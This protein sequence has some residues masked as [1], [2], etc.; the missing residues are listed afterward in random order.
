MDYTQ[1][2]VDKILEASEGATPGPWEA[3]EGKLDGGYM[4]VFVKDNVMTSPICRVSPIKA[5]N[6]EDVYN[7]YFL[8]GAPILAEEVKR[9]RKENER[10]HEELVSLRRD[11]YGDIVDRTL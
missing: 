4:G 7:A 9:L 1:S 6:E 3:G 10:L 11:Y 2:D 5:M 8:A